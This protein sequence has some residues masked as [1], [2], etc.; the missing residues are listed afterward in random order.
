M[1][2]YGRGGVSALL[3]IM[4]LAITSC[5]PAGTAIVQP[6]ST[7]EQASATPVDRTLTA[8]IRV[9]PDSLATRSVL[10]GVFASFA[11][12]RRLFNAELT[13]TDER[14]VPQPYLADA[15]P[16]LNTDSWR[17]TPDG[18]M[19]T[20]WK[21][22][23]NLVWHDETPLSAQ[24]FVFAW[25][26]YQ[27]PEFGAASSRSIRSIQEVTAPDDRTVLIGWNQ[28]YPNADDMSGTDGLPPLPRQILEQGF[29]QSDPAAFANNLFWT[30]EY[31]GLGPYKLEQ[32]EP[33]SYFQGLAF[34]QHVLGRPKITRIRVPFITDANTGLARL[35][36][37]EL[38]M[39][40]DNSINLEQAVELGTDWEKRGLGAVLYSSLTWQATAFQLRPELVQPQSLLD[41]RVR[42]ALAQAVDKQGFSNALYQG[43]IEISDFL[44]SPRS[45]WGPA[46]EGA[47]QKYPYDLRRS[48][49]LMNEAGFSRGA[50]GL[51]ASSAEGPFKAE[52]K[53]VQGREQEVTIMASNWRKAGFDIHEAILPTALS[54]DPASRVTFPS[55]FTAIQGQGEG[56]L[57]NFTS[58]QI[59]RTENNW[60]RGSN[61]GGWS[62]T[63]YDRLFDAFSTT[64]DP[65]QRAAQLAKMARILTEDVPVIPL[66]LPGIPYAY[67]SAVHGVQPAAPEGLI[68]WN[69]HEWELR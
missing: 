39:A 49:Q 46:I 41:A 15:Q 62:N 28:P 5:A 53:I 33:G 56:T 9:E 18:H 6:G 59:P 17:V 26:V 29:Q 45:K 19:E 4:G 2:Q 21:L 48:E 31:V 37:G 63:E 65:K 20:T 52:L 51:F 14:G 64:L 30:R 24:D 54:I 10:S 38:D 67:A 61:R 16:Q 58:D 13:L 1:P 27:T 47:V 12:A 42:K 50:D 25:H 8:A 35:L 40:V 60:R 32:W 69:V 66:L 11:L 57:V 34:A 43:Q 68:S 7:A 55:M 44:I 3:A 36:A 22:K 23:P